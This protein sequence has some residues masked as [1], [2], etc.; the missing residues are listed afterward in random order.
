MELLNSE[1]PAMTGIIN[2]STD[3]M[4]IVKRKVGLVVTTTITEQ[5][6]QSAGTEL[7]IRIQRIVTT[8][9]KDAGEFVGLYRV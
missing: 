7:S 4:L 6:A 8:E 5:S 9:W 2:S 3:V 1:R